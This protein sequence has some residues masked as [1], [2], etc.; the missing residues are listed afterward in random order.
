MFP[1]VLVAERIRVRSTV[2]VVVVAALAAAVAAASWV[3]N[4]LCL[5][6]SGMKHG[7]R[8]SDAPP[9]TSTNSQ[10]R[11][12]QNL[13]EIYDSRTIFFLYSDVIR[14]PGRISFLCVVP[15]TS[16]LPSRALASIKAGRWANQGPPRPSLP[17]L[18]ASPTQTK[19][20]QSYRKFGRSHPHCTSLGVSFQAASH[21]FRGV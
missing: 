14:L 20:G 13:K 19:R 8:S 12:L 21:L 4:N 3:E 11:R 9:T 18:A 17:R 16:R 15:G 2:V 5:G 7:L 6:V 1:E 10:T